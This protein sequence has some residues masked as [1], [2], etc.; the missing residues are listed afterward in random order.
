MGSAV[1][2]LYEPLIARD[3]DA[4]GPAIDQ[5][6]RGHSS[7]DLYLAVARFAV[8]AYA[9]SQHSK[10]A[11]LAAL[12][13]HDLRDE[14]RDEW[15]DIVYECAFYAAASRQPWSEPPIMTPPEV[16]ETTP[17]DA[18]ELRGAIAA[19]DRLRAERWLAR[20]L[21]DSALERDLIAVASGDPI[22]TDA[23]L[24]LVPILGEKGRYVLLRMA[25]W[26]IT[27]HAG[28]GH[29]LPQ[30]LDLLIDRC[31]KDE[32]S[33]ESIHEVFRF[34]AAHRG[35][36]ARA[37][38]PAPSFPPPPPYRLGRDLAATLIAHA[39]ARYLCQHFPNARID[40]FL[41]AVRH[42]LE[43][44]ASLEDWSFA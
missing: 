14:Y 17:A 19:R 27:S 36:G 38:P 2:A 5:F 24:R 34:A 11:V 37:I 4:I 21:N 18:D 28:E 20:R 42:N 39:T 1:S 22:I 25:V 8:L 41:K 6:R 31:V 23:A 9:P 7:E 30:D 12:A 35:G 44:A 10:H 15:D 3:L 40:A 32:G 29:A 33:L 13:A 43:T 26:D 16:D